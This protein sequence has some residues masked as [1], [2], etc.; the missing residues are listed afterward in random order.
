MET[1][2]PGIADIDVMGGTPDYTF[3]WYDDTGFAVSNEEDLTGDF[4]TGTYFVTVT[5]AAGC[6]ATL[7]VDFL[8][9]GVEGQA[10]LRPWKGLSSPLASGKFT[11][12]SLKSVKLVETIKKISN[13]NTTSMSGVTLTD[14][15]SLR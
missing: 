7:S 5:D 12:S 9:S 3:I 1:S 4:P 8:V 15:A 6:S 14:S 13:R 11:T 10:D 2:G